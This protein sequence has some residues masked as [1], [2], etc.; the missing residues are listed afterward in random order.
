MTIMC[1]A[2]LHTCVVPMY[3]HGLGR[4][5]IKL[6]AVDSILVDL[7]DVQVCMNERSRPIGSLG[8]FRCASERYIGRNG[9]NILKYFANIHMNVNSWYKYNVL[10]PDFAFSDMRVCLALSPSIANKDYIGP[11]LI[12]ENHTGSYSQY[13][14][15]LSLQVNGYVT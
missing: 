8:Y 1:F 9:M 3:F 4:I 15:L 5:K 10:V 13:E 6:A 11:F 14:P 12:V 2:L 7:H